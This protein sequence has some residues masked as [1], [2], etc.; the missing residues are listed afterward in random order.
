MFERKICFSVA[1]AGL[2][3]GELFR[4]AGVCFYSCDANMRVYHLEHN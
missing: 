2:F 4:T 3:H 1:G